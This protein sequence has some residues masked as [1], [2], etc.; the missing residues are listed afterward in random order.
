MAEA[1]LEF[2]GRCEARPLHSQAVIVE[3]AEATQLERGKQYILIPMAIR[4]SV[5]SHFYPQSL[6]VGRSLGNLR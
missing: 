5:F 1:T 3:T 4:E 2:G 6:Q